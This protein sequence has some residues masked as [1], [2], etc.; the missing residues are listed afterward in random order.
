MQKNTIKYITIALI[1]TFLTTNF[2]GEKVYSQEKI[3]IKPALSPVPE[4]KISPP[5]SFSDF[6]K[7]YDYPYQETFIACLAALPSSNITVTSYNST[8]GEIKAKLKGAK[9]LY[10]TVLQTSTAKAMIRVTP[11]DGSYNIPVD[12]VKEFFKNI[13]F[14]LANK[15]SEK[16]H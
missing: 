14:E 16:S 10:I 5:L 15:H 2:Y 11:T 12:T 8:K 3:L 13:N 9:E 7:E 4:K 1:S 6:V